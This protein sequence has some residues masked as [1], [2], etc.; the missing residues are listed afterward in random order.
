MF[1]R[2]HYIITGDVNSGKSTLLFKQFKD[3]TQKGIQ[4]AGWI[5]PPVLEEGVKCGH[6]I[7]I[8]KDSQ[9]ILKSTLTRN[10]HFH[11]STKWRDY[12]F[13][14][15]IFDKIKKIDFGSPRIFLIDEAGPLELEEKKGFWPLL[16][17]I[18]DHHP[19]TITAV[20][21]NILTLFQNAFHHIHF[22]QIIRHP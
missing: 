12:W 7:H 10:T 4:M 21:K 18:Y 8:I 14:F 17:N 2:G 5:S 1:E 16:P 15:K 6:D 3:C 9:I 13:D 20:R 19:S 22:N 11:G